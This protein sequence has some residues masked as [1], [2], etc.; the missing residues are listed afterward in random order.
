MGGS[1]NESFYV[2]EMIYIDYDDKKLEKGNK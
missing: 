1:M 2:A